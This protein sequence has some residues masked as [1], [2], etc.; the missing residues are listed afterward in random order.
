MKIAVLYDGAGLA[1]LGLEQAG[2]E[3]VGVELNPQVH[4]M[5]KYVG[6]G[7]CILGDARKFDLSG[8][9]AVWA[10]PPCQWR[11]NGRTG[12]APVSIYAGTGDDL[13]WCL[14]LKHPETLWVEN[15]WRFRRSENNWG[16]TYNANQFLADPIQNRNRVIG[17]RYLLPKVFRSYQ[18]Y[19]PGVCPS[20]TATEYKGSAFD[21]RRA[22]KFYGRRLTV[23]ECAYHQGFIIPDAWRKLPKKW[24]YQAIG[25]GVPV[26]MAKLFGEAYNRNKEL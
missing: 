17:G 5:G 2:H 13:Q 16:K 25:N 24:I 6:S 19:I 12:A 23:D 3:C 9:D 4:A 18:M 22:S 1:R 15:T 8:F 7:N 11:A 14:D 26:Y 21:E 10:S 20:I